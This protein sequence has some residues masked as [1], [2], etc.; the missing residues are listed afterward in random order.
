[1]PVIKGHKPKPKPKPRPRHHPDIGLMVYVQRLERHWWWKAWY[2]RAEVYKLNPKRKVRIM[3]DVVVGHRV[4]NRIVYLD[5]FGQPMLT[6]PVPDSPP[7]WTKLAEDTVDTM[8]VSADGTVD[9]VTAVGPG[10]DSLSVKVTVG[11]V[12]YFATEQIS[13]SA[14][15]QELGSV[16]IAAEVQ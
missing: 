11:G 1:M 14:A 6:T 13:I 2:W 4:V 5:K 16:D 12:D 3:T 15:P 8:D 10:V 7:V 9:T